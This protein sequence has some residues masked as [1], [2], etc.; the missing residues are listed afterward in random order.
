[1][2]TADTKITFRSVLWWIHLAAVCF[3]FWVIVIRFLSLHPLSGFAAPVLDGIVVWFHFLGG[4]FLSIAGECLVVSGR[5]IHLSLLFRPEFLT[6]ATIFW[7]FFRLPTVKR[8]RLVAAMVASFALCCV[9]ILWVGSSDLSQ[10]LDTGWWR[11]CAVAGFIL[12]TWLLSGSPTVREFH[13][14]ELGIIYG[15]ALM[16]LVV[17]GSISWASKPP[18]K[19]GVIW[20]DETHGIWEPATCVID[21][22]AYGRHTQYNY[23]LMR[24]WLERVH[25]VR[26]LSDSLPDSLGCD[27]LLIKIPTRH[28]SEGES[29][30][31]RRFVAHGG[32]LLVI[33]D[34]TNLFGSTVVANELLRSYGLEFKSDAT[35]PF[36]GRD[37]HQEFSWWNSSLGL[38]RL[39]EIDFQTSC[40]IR[41]ARLGAVP[42]ILAG[43]AVAER[44]MYS[45]DRFFGDLKI[46]PD[47]QR[48]PLALSACV[49]YKKGLVILFG[50]STIWSSFSFFTPPYKELLD[51]IIQIG[52]TRPDR[53]SIWAAILAL[54]VGVMVA[55]IAKGGR[56][57]AGVT[58]ALFI[59]ASHPVVSNTVGAPELLTH[60]PSAGRVLVDIKRSDIDLSTDIRT[61]SEADIRTYSAFFALWPRIGSWPELQETDYE[62]L[63]SIESVV[64]V[65]PKARVLEDA[66]SEIERFV[67]QGGKVLLMLDMESAG[68]VPGR[69]FLENFG[70]DLK[71]EVVPKR[72]SRPVGPSL[73]QNLL[74]LPL[75]LLYAPRRHPSSLT[76]TG[77]GLRSGLLGVEPLLVDEHGLCVFGSRSIG[78]GE[79]FVFTRSHV[80]SQYVLGDVWGGVEPD[81]FRR[82]LYSQAYSLLIQFTRR[83]GA[84]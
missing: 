29:E 49:S 31:I 64:I 61:G 78:K 63:D 2:N 23:V 40:S 50:D 70:I 35:V 66:S 53:W 5:D 3:A 46:T 54:A 11:T 56:T 41:S 83:E 28:Y 1:M 74:G 59:V 75:S 73:S 69:E 79:L 36:R 34:H 37:Y 18:S 45:N 4:H 26:I 51:Q 25:T 24:Q 67:R 76:S 12:T 32:V 68:P 44:A 10:L 62:K 22:T 21:T 8:V 39:S 52:F 77:A 65:H 19:S 9:L 55:A 58:A 82:S 15:V 47:D 17:L 30:S 7:F 84:K 16:G 43:E 71:T 13:R 81:P 80:F 14:R 27:L 60:G 20:I 33:G 38:S 72:W 42:L 48:S 6:A 57:I